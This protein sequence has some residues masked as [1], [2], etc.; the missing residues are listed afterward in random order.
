MI[1]SFATSHL[2]VSETPK[3]FGMPL[4]AHRVIEMS[5][6]NDTTI[7]VTNL[8]CARLHRLNCEITLSCN[9]IQVPSQR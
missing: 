8:T 2:N 9:C 1:H 6:K 3:C 4:K 7:G 5:S